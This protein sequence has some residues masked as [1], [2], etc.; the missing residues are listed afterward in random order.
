MKWEDQEDLSY[1]GLPDADDLDVERRD[2]TPTELQ[3]ARY[4]RR[5]LEFAEANIDLLAYQAA[6]RHKVV[7]TNNRDPGYGYRAIGVYRGGPDP[8]D[9]LHSL[10]TFGA[11]MSAH[12]KVRWSDG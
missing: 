5:E 9:C 11:A 6:P 1:Q 3:L 10:G 2:W 12:R 8:W 7:I 4:R